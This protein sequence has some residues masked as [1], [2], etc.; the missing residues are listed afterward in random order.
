[1][2]VLAADLDISYEAFIQHRDRLAERGLIQRVKQV[3][4]GRGLY[5]ITCPEGAEDELG[6]ERDPA[7]TPRRILRWS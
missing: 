5:R 3:A 2:K 4:F 1:M 6:I 7:Q